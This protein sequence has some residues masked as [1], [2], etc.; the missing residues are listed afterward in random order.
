MKKAL[1][2][3]TAMTDSPLDERL[4]ALVKAKQPAVEVE[5]KG[6]EGAEPDE[7]TPDEV[8]KLRALLAQS[9]A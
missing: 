2:D 8:E 1:G 7:L 3:L 4:D 9:G 5:V 6:E